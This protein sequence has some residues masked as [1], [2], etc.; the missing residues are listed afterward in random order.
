MLVAGWSFRLTVYGSVFSWDFLSGRAGTADPKSARL[1]AFAGKG[2]AG[3]PLRSLG[4]VEPTPLGGWCFR[5]RPWLV[6]PSRR[7][8]LGAPSTTAIVRGTLS[9]RLVRTGVRETTLTRF[10]PRFRG[11]EAPLAA[12]LGAADVLDGRIVRGFRAAWKY[13]KEFVALGDSTD[14]AEPG[15]PALPAGS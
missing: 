11:R 13:L 12:H 3:P 5:W 7:V 2:L 14:R 15:P 10:P 4:R 8:D 1:L 6:L 9:P